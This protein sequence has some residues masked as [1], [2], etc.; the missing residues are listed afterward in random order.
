M[1]F[2]RVVE[3]LFRKLAGGAFVTFFFFS[4]PQRVVSFLG[5]FP[6]A[7]PFFS[8]LKALRLFDFL[9]RPAADFSLSP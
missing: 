1:D 8:R 2:E 9:G 5:A 3:R 7:P 4:T 6:S